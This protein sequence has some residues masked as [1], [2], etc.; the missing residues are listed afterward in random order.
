[1]DRKRS[2]AFRTVIGCAALV[3]LQVLCCGGGNVILCVCDPCESQYE[4]CVKRCADD[5]TRLYYQCEQ[6]C[7][8]A[9]SGCEHTW[10]SR[11]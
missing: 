6:D 10:N 7:S 2:R 4:R 5:Q 1:M 3:L 9:V 8:R 11:T